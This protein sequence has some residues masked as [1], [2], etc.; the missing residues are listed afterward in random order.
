MQYSLE[1]PCH[2]TTPPHNYSPMVRRRS[3]AGRPTNSRILSTKL[4]DDPDNS[5]FSGDWGCPQL[6]VHKAPTKLP[7]LDLKKVTPVEQSIYAKVEV[8]KPH[9]EDKVRARRRSMSDL[10]AQKRRDYDQ[11]VRELGEKLRGR[12]PARSDATITVIIHPLY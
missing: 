10:M 11:V 12:S 2:P 7:S 8:L 6:P 1:I 4:D 9:K 5:S 3:F